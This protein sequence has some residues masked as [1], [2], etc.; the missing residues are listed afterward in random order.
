MDSVARSASAGGDLTTRHALSGT[1]TVAGRAKLPW[2][3]RERQPDAS[4][5]EG[6]PHFSGTPILF[7]SATRAAIRLYLMRDLVARPIPRPQRE[8]AG[9]SRAETSQDRASGVRGGRVQCAWGR[10]RRGRMEARQRAIRILGGGNPILFR[11]APQRAIPLYLMRD[12]V[13]RPIS[14]PQ[15]ERAGHL[16]RREFARSRIRCSWRLGPVRF[17]QSSSRTESWE[18]TALTPGQWRER[19]ASSP[20]TPLTP[21]DS[22]QFQRSALCCPMPDQ[23]D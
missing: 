18:K 11:S 6:H 23:T 20:L 15:R 16:A 21:C 2:S 8:R 7:H 3:H 14:R 4:A 17:R 5:A 1:S 10:H 19:M 13:N 12:L 9:I 22:W